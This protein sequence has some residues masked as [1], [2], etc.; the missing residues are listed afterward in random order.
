M[1]NFI[2]NTDIP[3]LR[4]IIR[5]GDQY[6]INLVPG[7]VVTARTGSFNTYSDFAGVAYTASYASYALSLSGS[8]QSA[9]YAQTAVSSSYVSLDGLPQNLIS[10]SNQVVTS[11]S[12][13]EIQPSTVTSNEFNLR[14]GDVN[15]TFT[16]SINTGIFGVSEY[17]QPFISTQSYSGASIEYVAQRPGA[18]RM[19]TIMAAWTNGST[20]A[21]TDFSTSDVGDTNDISFVFLPSGSYYRLRVN[22]EG[23]GTGTWTVQTLFKLFP[24]LI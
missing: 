22:S 1:S 11:I 7:R 20:I 18:T 24:N 4:V 12:G 21:F 16:G 15:I 9:S 10:S 6:S 23:T 5:D 17:I 3:N 13:S 14:A 8:V 2:V 19:G